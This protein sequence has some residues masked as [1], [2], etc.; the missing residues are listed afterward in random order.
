MTVESAHLNGG[1]ARAA[2]LTRG[3]V[4]TDL[5][6]ADD[7]AEMEESAVEHMNADHAEAVALYAAKLLGANAG[8]WRVT[9]LDPEGLDLALGDATLRLAFPRPVRDGTALRAVLKELADTARGV[10]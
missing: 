1:F 3:D 9:G 8:A 5:A 6:G 7:F 2:D 4:L 10:A